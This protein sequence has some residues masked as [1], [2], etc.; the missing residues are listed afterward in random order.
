MIA[1]AVGKKAIVYSPEE[2]TKSGED[3]MKSFFENDLGL[4]SKCC[5]SSVVDEQGANL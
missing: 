4:R 5:S 3:V 2:V 1:L